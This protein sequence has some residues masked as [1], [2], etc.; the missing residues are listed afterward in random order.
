[1]PLVIMS[2]S[3]C[4]GAA[5]ERLAGPVFFGAGGLADEHQP[6][7]RRAVAK[8]GL[9]PGRRQVRAPRTDGDLGRQRGEL[10]RPLRGIDRR[11]LHLGLAKQRG[12]R[13]RPR[14]GRRRGPVGRH[15]RV[16]L[17]TSSY[18]WRVPDDARAEAGPARRR[19]R[20]GRKGRRRG[21]GRG[22][23]DR[24]RRDGDAVEARA[25]ERLQPLADLPDQPLAFL[26]HAACSLPGIPRTG[27]LYK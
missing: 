1:M 2:V 9:G 18:Q 7:G 4:A 11:Q 5:D 17:I 8:D 3:S 21:C 16:A 14:G 19:R 27:S 22:G 10:R 25:A 23:H 20:L 15:R 6:G 24:R 13:Q 26:G 12:G